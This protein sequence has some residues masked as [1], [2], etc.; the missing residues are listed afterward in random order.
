[1]S[2]SERAE[3]P[4][5]D[6]GKAPE[7]A[8]ES[9]TTPAEPGPA[10]ASIASATDRPVEAAAGSATAPPEPP[11]LTSM[12]LMEH[13]RELRT[14]LIRS[15]VALAVGMVVS[16]PLSRFVIS[17]VEI[18]LPIES[19]RLAG[20]TIA[21]PDTL[22]ITGLLGMCT[23]CDSIIIISP[24]EGLITWMR[25]GL[26]LGL[27]LSTPVILYQVVAFVLPALYSRERRYLYLLLP[28]AGLMFAIGLAFGFFVVLPRSINF[29]I[30][31]AE[32]AGL[33]AKPTPT[34][35]NYIAF[36]SNL[37]FVIGVS[38]ETPLVVFML[39]KVGILK[40]ATMSRYRR[41]AVLVIAILAAVLT[42]TPDPFTMFLVMAP[43]YLLYELGGLLARIF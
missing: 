29:L 25:V 26:I 42:P 38:F 30:G 28:G 1:M 35:A 23:A 13:L 3:R 41:H 22:A 27:I 34:L 10:Q 7:S 39:A 19:L 40:P 6:A 2:A 24:L 36:V 20:R 32:G 21:L 31:F 18:P 4:E 14:R 16:M 15:V 33:G 37:L 11:D 12:P 9:A 17:G 43:M 8:P 5:L